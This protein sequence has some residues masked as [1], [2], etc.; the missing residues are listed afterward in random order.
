MDRISTKVLLLTCC[1]FFLFAASGFAQTITIGTIDPGPYGQGSTIAAPFELN[2]SS[3][4]TSSTNIFTL[5]LSDAAGNFSSATAIGTYKG[6]YG[7]FVNGIIPT[8]TPAGSGYKLRIT[9]SDPAVL[10]TTSAPFTITASDG[11]QA[12]VTSQSINS[13]NPD[14]FGACIGTNNAAYPFVNA[15]SNGAATTAS[16][17]NE[18]S[19]TNEGTIAVD[20]HSFIAKAANYTVLARAESNGVVGTK[21][22]TLINNVVNNSFGASGSNLVCLNDKNKLTYIVDVSTANGIQKNYP[23][24]IYN[25]TWGDGSSTNYTLCDLVNSGGLIQH[26]YK[27]AS[28]G[29]VV[30]G[31]VNVFQVDLQPTSPFCGKVGTLVTGYAKVLSPPINKISGPLTGCTNTLV[32]FNNSSETGQDPN[33]KTADCS[34]ANAKYTWSVDG[35]VVALNYPVSQPFEHTFTSNGQHTVTL[36][37]QDGSNICD[38]KDVETTICIQNAPKPSFTLPDGGAICT[39]GPLKPVNTS[40]VDEVCNTG[41]VYKWI[42]K[43]PQPITYLSGTNANSKDPVF[44]F[45]A[46][47]VYTVQLSINTASCGEVLSS[48]GTVAVNLTPTATLSPDALLC[49][50]GLTLT[51][52]PSGTVTKTILTGT[53]LEL[54][55]TYTW[56]VGGGAYSFANGTTANSK[57]PQI[58]FNDYAVYTVKVTHVNNCGT[59]TDSQQLAFQEA[60]V[61]TSGGDQTICEGSS[62]TLEGNITGNVVSYKW[63]GGTGTFSPSRN[64][65]Q[66]VYTPSAAEISAGTVTLSLDALTTLAAPCNLISSTATIAITRKDN[67][68]STATADVCTGQNF[69]YNITSANPLSTYS[70]TAVLTSGNATGFAATGS[71]PTISEIINATGTGDAVVTYIIT[72]TTNGCPGNPFK[73]TVNVNRIPNISA[74]PSAVCNTQAANVVITSST[75]NTTYTWTSI[76][77]TGVTGNSKQTTP[78][79]ISAIQDALTN[80]GNANGTVTYTITPYH[81]ACS[82]A[83]IDVIV[84]VY[85]APVQASAGPDEA[86]CAGPTYQLKGNSPAP[87]TGVWTLASGQSGI[88]FSDNTN[89]NAIVSGL[90]PGNVYQFIWS[91]YSSPSCPPTSDAVNITVDEPTIAG[92]VAGSTTTCSG[93]NS[94]LLTLSGNNGKVLSW[95]S[96]T[97]GTTWV[98]IANITAQQSYLNLTQTTFYRAVVQNGGCNVERSST[99]TITVNQPVQIANA[100]ADFT[101]CNAASAKLNGNSPLPYTGHW[102]QVSGPAVT[103]A[104]AADPQTQVNGL[105][106]NNTYKFTWTITGLP[107]CG[108]SQ[109]TVEVFDAPDVIA[110]FKADKA[111]GCGPVTVQFSNTSSLITGTSFLWDFGDGSATSTEVNPVHTFHPKTDGRDTI[112]HVLLNLPGNCVQRSPFVL[113]ILV[114]PATP[115]IK[116]SPDELTGCGSLAIRAQN[117]S[118]GNNTGYDYYLYDNKGKLALPVIHKTDKS[119]VQFAALSPTVTTVY[120]LYAVA[121]GFCGTTSESTHIN[122]TVSPAAFIARAFAKDN[123][124]KGCA[125]LNATFVNISTSGDTFRYRITDANGKLVEEI[126]GSP[127]EQ[128]YTFAKP[129]IYYVHTIAINDCAAVVSKDSIQFEAYALPEPNFDADIRSGCKAITVSFSNLTQ[130]NAGTPAS[131]L[132]YD[133]DFGDGKHFSGFTPL[134]HTY[135]SKSPSYTVKLTV[136]N[137]ATGCAQTITKTDFVKVTAAPNVDFTATPGFITSIPNY[138]FAFDD[139]TSGNP[140]SWHWDFG[141]GTTDIGQNPSHTYADTGTYKVTLR[142]LNREGC[143]STIS[144]NVQIT[145]IPGQLY[146]PNAFMPTGSTTELQTFM[147]KGSG[148]ESWHMQ[149]FN[150][151]GQLVWETTKLSSK[152]EP[153]EGWD[154]TFKGSP[155]PQG[156]Y[157]W[158]ATAHFLNGTD[159]KGMSYNNS[160]PKRTGIIHLLR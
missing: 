20:G 68:T 98:N 15:S 128:P 62:A 75:A 61:V 122:I 64:V 113:D 83:P 31:Q 26:L 156:N 21:A 24:I 80:T 12:G 134:P 117:L 118:P 160:L 121:T 152:G 54:P 110:S 66:A 147:A 65:L 158:Q 84:T 49:G 67:I 157:V 72:P 3:G 11:I 37:L 1:L 23:G 53:Q 42:V 127:T 43:G 85:P 108:D 100:G 125:P 77:T 6:F 73:L 39:A 57:S 32:S 143:D 95:E 7:T 25:V 36:H 70:W 153:T 141:D 89:P 137:L 109:D 50:K 2:T 33:A 52:G 4:C 140:V 29:N 106:S 8:G 44:N 38:V 129:G 97:D 99:A 76:A 69:N 14:V 146:L 19:K 82:G 138:H 90:Q 87:G 115:I 34:N 126:Q 96:S 9:S 17:Y 142:V 13:D 120:T 10:P 132:S 16:F 114:R 148:I 102:T 41:T 123:L 107:P 139:R 101:V 74:S 45:T 144:H 135:S 111:E 78:V 63:S 18:L 103:F 48:T 131:S 88:T 155:A 105:I 71:G 60:P 92:T 112:Y 59:A 149:V 159:W 47:G 151:W 119:P 30:N 93:S 133:W 154:G 150:N 58:L 5:Y 55:G 27:A 22:Y 116:I 94:G 86:I 91:V 81:G 145:G 124:H 51:F 46:S 79:A 104:D 40:V 136:T 35:V 28:C 130:A 56:I